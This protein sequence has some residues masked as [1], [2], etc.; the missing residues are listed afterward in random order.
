MAPAPEWQEMKSDNWTTLEVLPLITEFVFIERTQSRGQEAALQT[1]AFPG[2]GL[3]SA[4][5][6]LGY[7]PSLSPFCFLESSAG[8]S[9]HE[10]PLSICTSPWLPTLHSASQIRPLCA[11]VLEFRRFPE[12]PPLGTSTQIHLT[13]R[14][15]RGAAFLTCRRTAWPSAP[16]FLSLG[17]ESKLCTLQLW[18]VGQ[19][20]PPTVPQFL[21]LWT[22]IPLT[23]SCH[24]MPCLVHTQS[25]S[26]QP[27][28][29]LHCF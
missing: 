16:P 13:S 14:G 29:G 20:L 11:F 10:R 15:F 22:R 19:V 24:G 3:G 12:L 18:V 28:Q 23:W 26:S 7:F 21:H 2:I 5:L 6:L 17:L 27:W 4:E 1:L 25:A 8:L 9:H